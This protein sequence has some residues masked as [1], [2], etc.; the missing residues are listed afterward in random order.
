MRREPSDASG[1]DRYRVTVVVTQDT[2]DSPL[3]AC[4]SPAFRLVLGAESEVLDVGRLTQ[5][6]PT[7]IRRAISHP[8]GGCIF[9]SCD[10]PPSRCDIHHCRPWE[11]GGPTSVANGALLCR[12]HHTF[13]HKNHWTITVEDGQPVTRKPDGD[14]YRICRWDTTPPYP[15][16]KAG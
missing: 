9:P 2:D 15:L 6:W 7:G 10:R 8:D 12:R 13:I 5:Q 16:D 3:A 1:P 14:P 4:D 11:H